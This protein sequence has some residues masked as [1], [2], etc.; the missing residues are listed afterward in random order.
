MPVILMMIILSMVG[1]FGADPGSMGAVGI[2]AVVS[3]VVGAVV[4]GI[5]Y[6][7]APKLMG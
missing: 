7:V 3:L 4:G 2:R 6:F 5:A 1:A